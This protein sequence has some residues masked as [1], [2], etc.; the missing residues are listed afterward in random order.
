MEPPC[1]QKKGVAIGFIAIQSF[2]KGQFP[3]SCFSI[4]NIFDFIIL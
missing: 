4:P 3:I 1:F 2:S